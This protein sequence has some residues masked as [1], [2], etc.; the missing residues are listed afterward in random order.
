MNN[1]VNIYSLGDC[2]GECPLRMFDLVKSNGRIVLES[3]RWMA[4]QDM[5]EGEIWMVSQKREWEGRRKS[6]WR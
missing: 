1:V 4:M 3:I 2:C 5:V 6:V